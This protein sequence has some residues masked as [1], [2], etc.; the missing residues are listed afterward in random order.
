[1]PLE[2]APFEHLCYDALMLVLRFLWFKDISLLI[3]I[4]FVPSGA[5]IQEANCRVDIV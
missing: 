2:A 1:M 3:I 5:E 4:L